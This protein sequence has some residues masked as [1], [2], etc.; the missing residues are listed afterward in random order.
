MIYE[1][2]LHTNIHIRQQKRCWLLLFRAFF[3]SPR[4]N[5]L[6]SD[7][8]VLAV[9]T[10]LEVVAGDTKAQGR[11]ADRRTAGHSQQQTRVRVWQSDRRFCAVTALRPPA[12]AGLIRAS[13]AIFLFSGNRPD[14]SAKYALFT[15]FF[16]SMPWATHVVSWL[17]F[18]APLALRPAVGSIFYM[19][20]FTGRCWPHKPQNSSPKVIAQ[21]AVDILTFCSRWFSVKEGGIKP[22]C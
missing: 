7:I 14:C 1:N 20:T 4:K 8:S 10:Q 12:A 15:I 5:N 19:E 17:M 21:A 6:L 2:R 3:F 16:W 11:C 18:L 22:S 13:K 9:L